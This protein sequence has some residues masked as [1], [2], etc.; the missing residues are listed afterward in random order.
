[1]QLKLDAI[2]ENIAK[3]ED[4]KL[5]KRRA[6]NVEKDHTEAQAL[7]AISSIDVL[8]KELQTE[9]SNITY[10]IGIAKAVAAHYES[11][12]EDKLESDSAATAELYEAENTGGIKSEDWANFCA[13]T[14]VSAPE[15]VIDL[16]ESEADKEIAEEGDGDAELQETGT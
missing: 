16:P 6:A 10:S 9:S 14:C 11:K 4:G 12:A 2:T 8:I 13:K 5:E 7:D 1:M 15:G 3:L